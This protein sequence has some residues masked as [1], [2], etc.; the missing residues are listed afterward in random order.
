MT[1]TALTILYTNIGRGHPFY[2]DGVVDEWGRLGG[3]PAALEIT[4]VFRASGFLPRQLWKTM[5]ALYRHGSSP[6]PASI[7]YERIRGS[8]RLH[9]EGLALRL[10]GLTLRSRYGGSDTPLLVAHPLLVSILA[11]KSGLYY[12]HGEVVTPELAVVPG[13]DVVFVPTEEAAGPFLAGGYQEEQVVITGLCIEPDIVPK[14]DEAYTRRRLRFEA[15]EPLTGAYFSSGAEP[16]PHVQ[17]LTAA[18]VSA[19]RAGGR[20]VIFAQE[21]G[22]L[23]KHVRNAMSRA[24]IPLEVQAGSASQTDLRPGA[25][26]VAYAS[27][28]ELDARVAQCFDRFDYFVA[29]AH[30][31]THWALGLGLPMFVLAPH[32]GP[33]AP[34]NHARLAA[35]GVAQTLALTRDAAALGESLVKLRSE[36]KLSSMA[37][38]GFGKHPIHGF[39]RIA[40][41]LA[42]HIANAPT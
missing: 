14:A 5:R 31:R 28:A 37:A 19:V 25:T 32:I 23:T 42:A 29:P 6:G 38:S 3:D 35:A 40:D 24:E 41:F 22:S 10:A 36:G 21:V 26:L 39:I 20:V 15:R 16:R 27:R 7:L 4:D 2:L 17:N 33:F 9:H 12:Q 34:L 8:K 30:E 18:A 11:G 13:A 1:K